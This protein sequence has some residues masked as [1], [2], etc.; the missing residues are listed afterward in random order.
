MGLSMP[1]AAH[2]SPSR[3]EAFQLSLFFGAVYFIQG[4]GEPTEGL[5]AQPV[6]SL[7]LNWHYSVEDISLFAT[8]LSVPWWFK[9]L[10]GLL[11]DFVPL[12]GYRRRSYLMLSTAAT[13]AGLLYL[14]FAPLSRPSLGWL[15]AVL[16][17]P[18]VGVAFSDVVA[19]ALMVEKGQPRGLTGRLQ[20]IQ[21][22]CMQLASVLVGSLGGYLSA[23]GMQRTGFLICALATLVTLGLAWC[24][25]REEPDFRRRANWAEV[26]G[27]LRNAGR[28]RAIWAVGAFLFLW[29]FNP[30]ST[31]VLYFYM[32]KE[33]HFTEQFYGHT[34]SL[35]SASMTV[36]CI[37]YGLYCRRVSFPLLVH[38][39]IVLGIVSTIAY[40]AMVDRPTAVGVSILIGFTY[41][42][43]NLIQFDF[44]ARICP[45]RTAGTVFA[46]L[47]ALTNAGMTLSTL[48]GGYVYS[49]S[50]PWWGARTAFNAMVLVGALTTAACWFLIPVLIGPATRPQPAED[51]E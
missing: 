46:L 38:L 19:D 15:L 21:W 18:T 43:A 4:I 44:A 13:V 37:A 6:R 26:I 47:M 22:S 35:M 29:N 36:A 12:G 7:L 5:I 23:N 40:W 33:L 11:S 1:T 48:V 31:S 9:P 14:S 39:S 50:R 25:V 16:L 27:E 10:Y 51:C 32:V 34:V 28:H 24:F 30:F 42:T 8:L 41:M 17:I 20:S 45:P 3:R 2:A 49:I